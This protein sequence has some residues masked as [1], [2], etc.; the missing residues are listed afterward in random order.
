[1]L[2]F[3]LLCLLT[4]TSWQDL[5]YGKVSNCWILLGI[6]VF[7]TSRLMVFIRGPSETVADFFT[8]SIGFMLR[9]ILVILIFFVLFLFHMMGA[10]DIK[11]MAL[12]GGYLGLSEGFRIIFYGLT[13]SALWSLLFMIHKKNLMKRIQYFFRFMHC[14]FVTGEIRAYHEKGGNNR[15]AGIALVP[16]FWLGFLFRLAEQGGV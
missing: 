7:L 3:F 11:V 4:G 10:G 16:F 12:I 9:F 13:A 5:R 6:A 15:Q 14:F 1:M 8:D 2:T